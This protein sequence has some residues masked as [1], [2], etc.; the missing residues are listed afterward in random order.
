MRG[1]RRPA[2][3]AAL[4]LAALDLAALDLAALDLAALGLDCAGL[5]DEAFLGAGLPGPPGVPEPCDA[6]DSAMA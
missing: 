3:L 5:A 1:G 6:P 4:D 2:D